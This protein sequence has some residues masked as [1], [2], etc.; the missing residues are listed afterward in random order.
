MFFSLIKPPYIN[1]L[2]D[3]TENVS[4]MLVEQRIKH[5]NSIMTGYIPTLYG[6][7]SDMMSV[8]TH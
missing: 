8:G 7:F 2:Q 1:Y 4:L 5:D 6:G 3:G